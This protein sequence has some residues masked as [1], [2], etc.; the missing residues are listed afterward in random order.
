MIPGA[1]APLASPSASL[2]ARP[3]P[4]FTAALATEADRRTGAAPG[5][6]LAAATEPAPLRDAAP[7]AN[8]EAGQIGRYALRYRIGEGGLGTV[9]AAH[10]PLL[11]RLI[12]IK[13]VHVDIPADQ[14]ASFDDLFLN[15]AKAAG[16]LSHP[17]IVTVFDAGV[18]TQGAYI[19][20]ELLKGK[21]LRQLLR[22]GWRPT[23]V[24]AALIVRRVADALA[25]AHSKGVVH[26]DIKPANIFMVGRT[27]PKVLD[28]GIARIM[29]RR[30]ASGRVDLRLD[31]PSTLQPT[32]IAPDFLG[33]SPYYM[34]P[35]QI[36]HQPVDRR[37]DVYALGVVLYELL[38][39]RRPFEGQTLAQV[40]DAVLTFQAPPAHAVRP[41]VPVALSR[42]AQRAMLRDLDHRTHSARALS[43]ELRQWLDSEATSEDGERSA[44]ADGRR[45]ALVA[46]GIALAA[47]AIG[48]GTAAWWRHGAVATLDAS[49]A[50]SP[51][52]AAD[53]MQPA[54]AA[55]PVAVD[56][57]SAAATATVPLAAAT[58]AP[59]P[60]GRASAAEGA[61]A[62]SSTTITVEAAGTLATP[63]PRAPA[64]N[65]AATADLE[66]AGAGASTRR[67][68]APAVRSPADG[69]AA[70]GLP[71]E[72]RTRAARNTSPRAAA[73]TG[74][75]Q[76]AVSP[77]GQVEV[78]GSHAGISPPLNQLTLPEGRHTVVLR[79]DAFAPH[80]VVVHVVAGQTVSVKHRFT[81]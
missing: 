20:M 32:T 28:F 40:H 21:D 3:H 47:V 74:S 56:P 51:P 78:D 55:R 24:Q 45:R 41:D 75:V 1:A 34:A 62:A 29:Q 46:S 60:G 58:E 14:R 18:S 52:T 48:L 50:A 81:P 7:A 66:R 42:I 22:D 65:A 71:R 77:W 43:R 16:R 9:Y 68:D 64:G 33:G 73:A 37:A 36:R 25:Y 76:I 53:A 49:S 6:P 4:T 11:S 17:H 69:A 23:P 54:S 13:T 8:A 38:T 59:A 57:T 15:E 35:E 26:R 61:S 63:A 27:Q 10:D 80:T 30:D 79:N 44:S 19:A 72:A 70:K 12:A 2:T 39:G 31:G 5:E 67:A